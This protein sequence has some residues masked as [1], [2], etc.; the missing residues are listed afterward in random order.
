[1]AIRPGISEPIFWPDFLA[2]FSGPTFWRDLPA[3]F[4]APDFEDSLPGH[5]ASTPDQQL[6]GRPLQRP[7][8][9]FASRPRQIAADAPQHLGNLALRHATCG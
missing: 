1:L 5:A 7:H 6:G 3:R 8:R 2:R 4:L 9:L